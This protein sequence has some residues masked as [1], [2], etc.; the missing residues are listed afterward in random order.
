LSWTGPAVLAGQSSGKSSVGRVT[1]SGGHSYSAG[2]IST[3][4]MHSYSGGMR[5][6]AGGMR[7]YNLRSYS[8]GMRTSSVGGVSRTR[9]NYESNHYTSRNLNGYRVYSPRPVNRTGRNASRYGTLTYSKRNST[10]T[11]PGQTRM[12]RSVNGNQVRNS[13]LNSANGRAS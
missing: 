3:S 13:D 7:S 9:V 5:S 2:T 1:S 10:A 4:G 8:G 6:Y 11:L 12:N